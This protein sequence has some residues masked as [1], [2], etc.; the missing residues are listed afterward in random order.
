MLYLYITCCSWKLT[1]W[2]G[3][4]YIHDK[5][6][7]AMIDHIDKDFTRLS[8]AYDLYYYSILTSMP[9]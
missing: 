3:F 7:Y 5:V 2:N 9:L 4:F 6:L 8:R 1:F